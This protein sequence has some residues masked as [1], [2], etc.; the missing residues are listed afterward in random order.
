M[1]KSCHTFYSCLENLIGRRLQTFSLFSVIQDD[2]ALSVNANVKKAFILYY[3]FQHFEGRKYNKYLVRTSNIFKVSYPYVPF[4][5]IV[6]LKSVQFFQKVVP[7]Y[8]FLR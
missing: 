5:C 6:S 2:V 8:L 1:L 4:R 3:G 7:F